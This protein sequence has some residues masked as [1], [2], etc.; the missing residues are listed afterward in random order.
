MDDTTCDRESKCHLD[1]DCDFIDQC[2]TVKEILGRQ[3]W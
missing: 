3:E 2:R 1:P